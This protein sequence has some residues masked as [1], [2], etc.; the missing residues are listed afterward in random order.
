MDMAL[1]DHKSWAL[2]KKWKDFPGLSCLDLII[3]FSVSPGTR[4]TIE[5]HQCWCAT[6]HSW[7]QGMRLKCCCS[8]GL[9][10][11]FKRLRALSLSLIR[12][13]V[14]RLCDG[15]EHALPSNIPGRHGAA[16]RIQYRE[17][18]RT[19][20]PETSKFFL[21]FR[22]FGNKFCSQINK[23]MKEYDVLLATMNW[24]WAL[25]KW[26]GNAR[27]HTQK[28]RLRGSIFVRIE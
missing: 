13:E 9:V 3:Q 14:S 15:K 8:V 2:S 4:L 27:A 25:L 6:R 16:F 11:I 12:W 18:A 7:R 28:R 24:L 20:P 22:H 10:W 19:K 17:P 1:H 5:F 21:L 23:V 26:K